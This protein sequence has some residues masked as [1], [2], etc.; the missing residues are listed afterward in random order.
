MIPARTFALVLLMGAGCNSAE[1]PETLIPV[2][3][4]VAVRGQPLSHGSIL[5]VPDKERGNK[6]TTQPSGS[7]KDG[8]YEL[9]TGNRHGAPAGIYK[10]AIIANQPASSTT[11]I[12]WLA[13]PRYASGDSGL[14]AEVVVDA[15]DGAYRFELEP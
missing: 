1:P 12:R 10:V 2:K 15:A 6:T 11:P 5:F 3:G 14:H 7:I 4:M 9:F 8:A 13:N